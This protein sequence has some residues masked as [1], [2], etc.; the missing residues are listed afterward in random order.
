M[1]FIWFH[2]HLLLIGFLSFGVIFIYDR[3]YEGLTKEEQI[4]LVIAGRVHLIGIE[5]QERRL[6]TRTRS[7]NYEGALTGIF[8]RLDWSL[9]KNDPSSCK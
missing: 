8:C 6:I 5:V 3:N 4:D 2:A 1:R 7:Q 9:H